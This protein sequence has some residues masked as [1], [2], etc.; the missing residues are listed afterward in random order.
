MSI[1]ELVD[2]ITGKGLFGRTIHPQQRQT[3]KGLVIAARILNERGQSCIAYDI[4]KAA[5]ALNEVPLNHGLRDERGD[6]L[7]TLTF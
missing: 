2:A 4:I 7:S 1:N 3:A 6:Y 5:Y